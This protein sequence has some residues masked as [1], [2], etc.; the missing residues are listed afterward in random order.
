MT[1]GRVWSWWR[2]ASLCWGA[3]AA[4]VVILAVWLSVNFVT[5]HDPGDRFTAFLFFAFFSVGLAGVIPLFVV[6]ECYKTRETQMVRMRQMRG[7]LLSVALVSGLLLLMVA[8]AKALGWKAAYPSPVVA[9]VTMLR[10]GPLLHHPALKS[11]RAFVLWRYRNPP[12]GFPMHEPGDT[13]S[14]RS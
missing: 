5:L 3:A 14:W 1:F 11:L 13:Y 10:L 6:A 8:V 2:A 9:V 12:P 7:A 4:L